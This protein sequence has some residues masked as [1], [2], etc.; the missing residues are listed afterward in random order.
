VAVTP[1]DERQREI[2]KTHPRT[3]T[4]VLSGV[5]FGAGDSAH[6]IKAP[7]AYTLGRL[8]D[9]GVAVS[10]TFSATSTQ[11]FVRVGTA[12]DPD[13]YAELQ[14]GTA[15][16]TNFFN[17]QDDPD[18]ILNEEINVVT[19]QLEVACIAPTGGTPTG[20]GDVHI[21]IDWF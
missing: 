8:I 10:E 9:V 15:A 21:V 17:T 18:A 19:S 3:V 4:Y 7:R 16:A 1:S 13:A 2:S 6:A 14:M 5:D 20:I 11:G 12:S